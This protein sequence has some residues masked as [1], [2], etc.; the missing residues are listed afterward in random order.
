MSEAQGD[1]IIPLLVLL[2]FGVWGIF[3]FGTGRKP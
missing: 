2:N 1:A 3:F